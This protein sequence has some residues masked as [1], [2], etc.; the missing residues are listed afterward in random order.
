MWN[1]FERLPFDWKNPVGYLIAVLCQCTLLINAFRYVACLMTL[2]I[3]S[4][5][6]TFKLLDEALRILPAINDS[7]KKSKTHQQQQHTFKL[8]VNFIRLHADIKQLSELH[9]IS[10]ADQC[11]RYIFVLIYDFRLVREGTYLYDVI[12]T[13]AFAGSTVAMCISMLM[14]EMEMVWNI[15]KSSFQYSTSLFCQ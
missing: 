13:A 15:L 11:W 5:I 4:Y 8:L 3:A 12:L 1:H 14:I 6:Y 10:M 9:S 2:G 7:V